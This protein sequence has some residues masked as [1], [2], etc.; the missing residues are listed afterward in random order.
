M[1]S[2]VC[3][4]GNTPPRECTRARRGASQQRSWIGDNI[5]LCCSLPSE[6]QSADHAEADLKGSEV[7]RVP[8]LTRSD[9]L[10][11]SNGALDN[12]ES[13][14]QGRVHEMGIELEIDRR[15]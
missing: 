12:D 6:S 13:V 15:I 1:R 10:M 5:A 11:K 4:N 9:T 7:V 2:A 3:G 8:A 14:R